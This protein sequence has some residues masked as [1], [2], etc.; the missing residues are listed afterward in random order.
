MIATNW[1]YQ[2]NWLYPLKIDRDCDV[3]C[4]FERWVKLFKIILTKDLRGY[5]LNVKIYL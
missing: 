4:E 3:L 5:S 1:D 2:K